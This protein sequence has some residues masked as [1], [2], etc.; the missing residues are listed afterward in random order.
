MPLG[1]VTGIGWR[2]DAAR[3]DGVVHARVLAALSASL[4]V[5]AA[6]EVLWIGAR[7]A[8]PHARAIHVAAMPEGSEVGTRVSVA[9]PGG[10]IAWRPADGPATAE[11]ATA[12]RRGAAR[13]AARAST[14]GP[15]RGF[16]GWLAGAPL[17]FPLQAAGGRA[18]TLARACAADDP[19]R[20]AEAAT[21]LLG[22]GPGMTPAGDDFVGGAFFARSARRRGLG[23]PARPRGGAG[24]R[25]RIGRGR[26][27][28]AAHE[29][30]PLLGLGSPR[31][32]RRRRARLTAPDVHRVRAPG[33]RP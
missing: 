6:G 25:R 22:L 4:Y 16:G 32:L 27:G 31:G 33:G 7:E 21:A 30:R 14:L 15:P 8:T 29:P 12:L 17:A 28:A 26:G 18:D 20:A 2:A 10:L 23:G 13:L 11:A 19:P 5:D 24:A 3:R 1:D 9:V